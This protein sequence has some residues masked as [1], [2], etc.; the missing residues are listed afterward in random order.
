MA[1]EL[2]DVFLTRNLLEEDN[3]SPGYWNHSAIYVGSNTVVEA[4]SDPSVIPQLRTR[5]NA[6]LL[7]MP[8]REKL[9]VLEDGQV[10][11]SDLDEFTTRYPEILVLRLDS[12]YI[13]VKMAEE[14]KKLIGTRYRKIASVFKRLRRDFRGHNCVSVV[15]SAYQKATGENEIWRIPDHILNSGYFTV[16]SRTN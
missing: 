7:S 8:T 3:T 2:G 15:R 11:A 5:N 14:A 4:Q 13:A 10:I 16:V 1:Y 9:G 6:P 12:E